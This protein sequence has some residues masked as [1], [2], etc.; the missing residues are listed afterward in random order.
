MPRRTLLYILADG[1]HAR[2]VRRDNADAPLRTVAVRD[3]TAALAQLRAA[4]KAQPR[5]QTHESLTPQSYSVGRSGDVHREKAR[6]MGE[7]ADWAVET[8]G[9]DKGIGV[10]IVAPTRLAPLLRRA[11]GRRLPIV[12]EL[13][14]DLIKVEDAGLEARLAAEHLVRPGPSALTA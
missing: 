6:F 5:G 4:L 1:A 2:L 3:H 8:A 13:H 7:V 12:G 11:L 10:V 14:K 9:K